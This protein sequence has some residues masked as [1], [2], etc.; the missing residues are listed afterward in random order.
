[1]NDTQIQRLLRMASEADALARS[2]GT[3]P[4]SARRASRAPWQARIAWIGLPAAAAAAIT[5]AVVFSGSNPGPRTPTPVAGPTG[6]DAPPI[7]LAAAPVEPHPVR[8]VKGPVPKQDEH[9]VV[10]AIFRGEQGECS[11]VQ[12]TDFDAG[13]GRRLA[14]VGYGELL[15]YALRNPCTNAASQLLVVGVAGR[16]GTLPD[17][18]EDANLL[19]SRLANVGIAEHR[20]VSLVAYAALPQLPPGSTVVA[21][22]VALSR[23]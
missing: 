13:E 15:A 19:A 6:S 21:E 3:F 14:D 22:A 16:R 7:T 10:L 11:C 12:L 2:E 20:D 4:F 23:R 5:L 18:P 9:S 17:T 1:M 8:L